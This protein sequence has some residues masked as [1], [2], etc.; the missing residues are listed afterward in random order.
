LKELNSNGLTSSQVA[1]ARAYVEGTVPRELI[2]TTDQLARLLLRLDVEGLG[3]DEI[4]NMFQRLDAVTVDQANDALK[5]YFQTSGLTFI[6]LGDAEKILPVVK[7]YAPTIEEI[8]IKKP[9]FT[10]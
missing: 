3:P 9:G 5:S 2:E 1:L 8:S 7:K 10:D 4:G 6:L